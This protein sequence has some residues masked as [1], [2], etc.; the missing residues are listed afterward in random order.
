[1]KEHEQRFIDAVE[2]YKSGDADVLYRIPA[3]ETYRHGDEVGFLHEDGWSFFVAIDDGEISKGMYALDGSD[4]HFPAA[5]ADLLINNSA[6]ENG[7]DRPDRLDIYV[8]VD[9][10]EV[11]L[12]KAHSDE[13]AQYILD[14]REYNHPDYTVSRKLTD[15]TEELE[16]AGDFERL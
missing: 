1:M 2:S 11:A 6:V 14:N 13:E 12:V 7:L 10:E 16:K 5:T 4:A 15:V 9:Y 3:R 8:A